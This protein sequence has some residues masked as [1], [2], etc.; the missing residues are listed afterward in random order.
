MVLRSKSGI[1][2]IRE[3]RD[4]W[5]KRV[6]DYEAISYENGFKIVDAT[7]GDKVAWINGGPNSDILAARFVGAFSDMAT[8]NAILLDILND[9]ERCEKQIANTGDCSRDLYVSRANL[10]KRSKECRSLNLKIGNMS[11]SIRSLKAKI[12][13]LVEERVLLRRNVRTLEN[14]IYKSDLKSEEWRKKYETEKARPRF[15][16]DCNRDGGKGLSGR[17]GERKCNQQ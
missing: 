3:V 10:K 6:G 8:M 9:L 1:A 2:A 7:T 16:A 17:R 14:R 11:R 4:R 15:V 5:S 12:S 13:K